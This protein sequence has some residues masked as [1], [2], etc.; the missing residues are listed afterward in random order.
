MPEPDI[1]LRVNGSQM[2]LPKGATI[3]DLLSQLEIDPQLV[4]VEQ[5]REIVPRPEYPARILSEKDT[6]EIVHFVGGG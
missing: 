2:K 1:S 3:R 6:I 5:N 4:A